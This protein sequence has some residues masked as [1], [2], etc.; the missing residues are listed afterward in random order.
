MD[1]SCTNTDNASSTF[2]YTAGITTAS[3]FVGKTTGDTSNASE[4]SNG[5]ATYATTLDFLDFINDFRGWGISHADAFPTTNHGGRCSSGTCQIWDWRLAS[6]NSV[7]RNTSEDGTNANDTFTAGTSCPDGVSGNDTATDQHSTPNTYLVNAMEIV[8]DWSGDEDGLCE[9]DEACIYNP[10][11]GA[12]MGEGAIDKGNGD[13]TC[14][15]GE[16]C[17]TFADGTV[18]GVL[19]YAYPT[20]GG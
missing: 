14:D 12:Y 3:A 19:L 20:N 18:T 9:T 15:S 11:F 2:S 10:N 16:D 13:M 7:V 1:S 6:A 8:G 4:D 5:Q 17:C